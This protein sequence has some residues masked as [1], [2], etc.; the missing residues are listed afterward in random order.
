[1]PLWVLQGKAFGFAVFRGFKGDLIVGG[2][3]Q[4]IGCLSGLASN[5]ADTDNATR[6]VALCW[7]RLGTIQGHDRRA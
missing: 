6:R 4:G 5:I 3:I 2:I 1:M 7:G